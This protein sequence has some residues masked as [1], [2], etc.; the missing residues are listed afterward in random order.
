MSAC[1]TAWPP[2]PMAVWQLEHMLLRQLQDLQSWG[3]RLFDILMK[4]W[5]F[6]C[7]LARRMEH[8]LNPFYLTQVSIQNRGPGKFQEEAKLEKNCPMAGC[9][10]LLFSHSCKNQQNSTKENLQCHFLL[11]FQCENDIPVLIK[12]LSL[13]QAPCHFLYFLCVY[14]N[15][16]YRERDQDHSS[17]SVFVCRLAAMGHQCFYNRTMVLLEKAHAKQF[18]TIQ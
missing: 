18:N 15:Q 13:G 12:L 8:F 9:Y 5:V 10:V 6:L 7:I 14:W 11:F 1:I 4:K 16:N 2:V 17:S 3:E